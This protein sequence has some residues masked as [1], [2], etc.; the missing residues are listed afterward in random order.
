MTDEEKND[1]TGDDSCKSIDFGVNVNCDNENDHT[2]HTVDNDDDND[3]DLVIPEKYLC[4][5]SHEIMEEPVVASDGYTYDQKIIHK[6]VT[7]SST[8][9]MTRDTMSV[10]E[11]FLDKRL[12][13]EIN[14]WLISNSHK[15][16]VRQYWADLEAEQQA[17]EQGVVVVV[18][19][20]SGDGNSTTGGTG[21]NTARGMQTRRRRQGAELD[22]QQLAFD[23]REIRRNILLATILIIGIVPCY[24]FVTG[25]DKAHNISSPTHTPYD[26]DTIPQQGEELKG[27]NDDEFSDDDKTECVDFEEHS[28]DCVGYARFN[29]A[30]IYCSV[31]YLKEACCF[32]GGGNII[33]TDVPSTLPSLALSSIPSTAISA[34]PS[35]VPSYS[36]TASCL[37]L[38][39]GDYWG[40]DNSCTTFQVHG[41]AFCSRGDVKEA[42]CFC[43]GGE[44]VSQPPSATPTVKTYE[45]NM[46]ISRIK[47]DFDYKNDDNKSKEEIKAKIKLDINDTSDRKVLE[48]V[49]IFL[50]W[51]TTRSKS[52]KVVNGT[53]SGSTKENGRK[54]FNTPWMP[55]EDV[56]E[57]RLESIIL[58]DHEYKEE[59]NVKWNDCRLF[60]PDCPTLTISSLDY[61]LFL[62]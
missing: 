50:A 4:T 61:E 12:Q 47:L 58:Y 41:M 25:I 48:N 28:V 31:Q 53:I 55:I 24:F 39:I 54:N 27:N 38:D 40:A 56:M 1:H 3:D 57:I 8:S 19:G 34:V 7:Q 11:W 36:P 59:Y 32:C 18:D 49:D 33:T 20:V 5:I 10:N 6:W 62:E 29:N 22:P 37:D 45:H 2:D 15:N 17:E 26:Y 21:V 35:T 13:E 60:T 44:V 52:G 30:Y 42:C 16:I 14:A 9:P 46:F 43:G 23:Q 51:N